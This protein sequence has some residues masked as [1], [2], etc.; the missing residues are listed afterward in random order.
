MKER[1]YIII[2]EVA[3]RIEILSGPIYDPPGTEDGLEVAKGYL[4]QFPAGAQI[5]ETVWG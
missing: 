4:K 3:G 5:A 2:R 1:F